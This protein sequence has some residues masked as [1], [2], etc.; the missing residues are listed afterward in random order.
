MTNIRITEGDTALLESIAP[1]WRRL[2][3]HHAGISVNFSGE[4]SAMRWPR[5]RADL[6]EKAAIGS[7]Y[8]AL[9]EDAAGKKLVGYCV[10]VINSHGCGEIESLYVDDAFRGCGVGTALVDK[11]MVWFDRK[12]AESTSVNVAIGN[13]SAFRFYRQWGFY[14]RVTSLVRKKKASPQRHRGRRARK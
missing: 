11:I 3:R 6:L 13:E 10:A 12:K 14:P 2:A 9:A 5:R 4:F 7:L 1:L 8:I